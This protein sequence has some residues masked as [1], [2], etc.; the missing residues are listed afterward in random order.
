[1]SKKLE[2]RQKPQITPNNKNEI[3]MSLTLSLEKML[4]IKVEKET[5]EPSC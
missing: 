4:L 3:N 2:K 1:M 5:R